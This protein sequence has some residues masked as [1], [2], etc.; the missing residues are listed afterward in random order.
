MDSTMIKLKE[1]IF[2]GGKLEDA[3][4]EMK[5]FSTQETCNFIC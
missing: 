2:R 4:L 3:Y 1:I 5:S